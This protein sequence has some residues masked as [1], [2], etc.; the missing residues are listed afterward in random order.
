MLRDNKVFVP[1]NIITVVLAVLLLIVLVLPIGVADNGDFDRVRSVANL[2]VQTNGTEPYFD[3][4]HTRYTILG[5][6]ADTS[7]AA[8]ANQSDTEI[9]E[10]PSPG[11]YITSHML[12]VLLTVAISSLFGN[13]FDI[14]LLAALYSLLFLCGIHLLL[15]GITERFGT[16]CG[17][18]AGILSVIIFGDLGY[19]AYFNSLYG[20][21]A[22][23]TFLILAAGGFVNL[24]C[25]KKRKI[26]VLIL[27]ILAAAM[28]VGSKQ[29]NSISIV[30]LLA[31]CVGLFFWFRD[32]I[33]RILTVTLSFTMVLSAMMTS[34]FV[35]EE[36]YQINI[37]QAVFIGLLDVSPDPASD[38][39]ALGL[40]EEMLAL[41]G[42]TYY[43]TQTPYPPNSSYMQREF[44]DKIS[45]GD[46]IR[47]YLTRPDRLW[48]AMMRT[49]EAAYK[50][51]PEY[52][53]N[54]TYAFSPQPQT[55]AHSY[56]LYEQLREKLSLV[57]N[58]LVLTILIFAGL[59]VLWLWLFRKSR[60]KGDR[61]LLWFLAAMA[62]IGVLQFGIPYIA[63]GMGD[64]VKH[65]FLY[66][67]AFDGLVFAVL[68]LF[69]TTLSG[70]IKKRIHQAQ[71]RKR[72]LP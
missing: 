32:R 36:I 51:L 48:Y 60:D 42:I 70:L 57:P 35:S 59:L 14:R 19:L 65:L 29:Q 66:N 23:Y 52:L 10:G 49:A 15:S 30:F 12:P 58:P 44:F 25:S 28:F 55:S 17:W 34:I 13:V 54:F 40:P 68:T 5:W 31:L 56:A 26:S 45:Y 7:I 18:I 11:I 38:L 16:R 37:H 21:A 50:N 33:W 39:K 24:F 1:A 53:S 9:Q 41:K 62:C 67:V 27:T 4:V 8:P 43:E 61:M 3:Y 2:E 64:I 72:I 63:D 69:F 22:S 47:V 20:E 46:I 6:K 71:H